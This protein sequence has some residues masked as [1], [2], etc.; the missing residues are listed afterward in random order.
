M[1]ITGV[2]FGVDPASEL[3]LRDMFGRFRRMDAQGLLETQAL[4]DR[5]AIDLESH[6]RAEFEAGTDKLGRSHNKTGATL[7]TLRAR[8]EGMHARIEMAGGAPFVQWGTPPHLIAPRNATALH[9]SG[10]DGGDVF[11][12]QVQH[13]GYRGDD[14]LGRAMEDVDLHHELERLAFGLTAGVFSEGDYAERISAS[15]FGALGSS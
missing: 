12:H 9:W 10:S 11:A 5:L 15:S 7:E 8:T 6:I 4:V 2:E 14:F 1:D 13:P 3:R